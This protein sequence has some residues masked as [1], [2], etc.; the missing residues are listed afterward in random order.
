ER[1]VHAAVVELDALPDSI[2]PAAENHDLLPIRRIGL[3]ELLVRRIHVRG[4]ARKLGRTAIDAF[5]D[6]TDVFVVA[7]RAN[8]LFFDADEL[9]D[10]PI[11]EA[12][13]LQAP[14]LR[15]RKDGGA[16]LFDLLLG[17]DDL[18]DLR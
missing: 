4:V 17:V 2:R 7:R 6:G 12:L 8:D 15:G 18:L 14:E 3:A 11:A 1:R 10:A 9:A 13:T 5:E 16:L